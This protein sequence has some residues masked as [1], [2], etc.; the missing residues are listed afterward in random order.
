MQKLK[1]KGPCRRTELTSSSEVKL[2]RK[3]PLPRSFA[4][5]RSCSPHCAGI[6]WRSFSTFCFFGLR[7][8]PINDNWN[9]LIF[10]EISWSVNLIGS[11]SSSY[12]VPYHLYLQ[13]DWMCFDMTTPYESTW[14]W[15]LLSHE[16][17]EIMKLR[18]KVVAFFVIS[19]QTDP[20][21]P[22]KL[23]RSLLEQS[24]RDTT[25]SWEW[26]RTESDGRY[27]GRC[28]TIGNPYVK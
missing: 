27:Q 2:R 13:G 20:D 24:S 14:Y 17:T 16:R 19:D 9:S 21:K 15:Y 4:F 3:F 22:M 25:G 1:W 11:S 5:M 28:R 6:L 26:N 23:F 8:L 7:I 18:R 12:R 10:W